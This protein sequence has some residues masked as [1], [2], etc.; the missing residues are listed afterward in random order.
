MSSAIRRRLLYLIFDG[1]GDEPH[2]ALGGRTPLAVA[3]TP[4]LDE[5]ARRGATFR[6]DMRDRVGDVSTSYGQFALFG[7]GDDPLLPERGPVEAAGIGISLRDG[8]VALRANWATLDEQGR[9]IDRRAGRIREG[10]AELSRALDGMRLGDGVRA[11][12]RNGTEHRVAV[13]FRGEGLGAGVADTDPMVTSILP[14]APREIRAIDATDERAQ[15]TAEK[16]SRFI[17]ASRDVLA[18]H[19]VNARRIQAGK[20]PANTLLTRCAGGHVLVPTLDQRFGIRGLA[21]VGG[22]T[23]MGVMQLLGCEVVRMPRFTAN[24]DTDLQGKLDQA[25]GGLASGAD[26]AMV[27]IKAIDILSH[28]RDPHACVRFLEKADALLGH[29]LRLVPAPTVVA[30]GADHTTSSVSGDHTST[31][32]P[33]LISGPGVQPDAVQRFNDA[34]L[35]DGAPVVRGSRFFQFILRAMRG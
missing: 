19:P 2:P 34:S 18:R 29:V 14:I 4:V 17:E 15:R 23:V 16:L 6:L 32:P 35:R 22:S 12:V 33:A 1:L 13:V 21:I 5:L 28:D 30:V 10:A 25:V 3:H 9:V 7:Y 20:P 27:H 8:D 24:V 31:P 11:M 26:F